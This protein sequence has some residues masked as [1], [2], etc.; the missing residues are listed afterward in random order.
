[1]L[2]PEMKQ[3]N[4][5]IAASYVVWVVGGADSEIVVLVRY[6]HASFA[7]VQLLPV[8]LESLTFHGSFIRRSNFLRG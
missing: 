6:T 3:T 8:I 1:M 2:E 4:R 5:N 7:A